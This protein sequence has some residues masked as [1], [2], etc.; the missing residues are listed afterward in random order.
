MLHFP[1]S[2]SVCIFW[3]FTQP[4]RSTP[5]P[6]SDPNPDLPPKRKAG[7]RSYAPVEVQISE[8]RAYA[9]N[10]WER[11]IGGGRT[12][13]WRMR[14]AGQLP[15]PDF[16]VGRSARWLGVTVKAFQRGELSKKPR[17]GGGR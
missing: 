11:V 15:E 2:P 13:V 4:G 1:L 17:R 10:V 7:T 8:D 3:V 5:C 6:L 14:L 16:F 9:T 12:A